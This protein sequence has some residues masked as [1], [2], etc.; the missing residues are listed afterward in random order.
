MLFC[1]YGNHYFEYVP[2]DTCIPYT[3]YSAPLSATKVVCRLCMVPNPPPRNILEPVEVYTP[4]GIRGT[5]VRSID[6]VIRFLKLHIK[7]EDID[8]VVKCFEAQK[9]FRHVLLFTNEH[10]ELISIG[11]YM[12]AYMKGKDYGSI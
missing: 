4:L 8:G 7:E 11:E 9:I 10:K 1:T 2:N 5:L 3:G 6:D 12:T